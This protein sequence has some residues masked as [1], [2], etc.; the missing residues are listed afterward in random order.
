MFHNN[1]ENRSQQFADSS[2]VSG[3]GYESIS[4][5]SYIKKAV[6]QKSL[7]IESDK[8]LELLKGRI[9]KEAPEN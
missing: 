6:R 2:S 5:T 3:I 4:N 7:N 1:S 9:I 8:M